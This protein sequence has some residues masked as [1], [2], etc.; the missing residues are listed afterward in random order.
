MDGGLDYCFSEDALDSSRGK[1]PQRLTLRPNPSKQYKLAFADS[2]NVV[3][4][5]TKDS[6]TDGF[7][8]QGTVLNLNY[9]G[10]VR[11]THCGRT[12]SARSPE[13]VDDVRDSVG[14]S[15]KKSL[16][17]RSQE[18]GIPRESMRRILVKDLQLHPYLIQIKH[19]LTQADMDKRVV[20]CQ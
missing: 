7:R 17:R 6:F 8:E 1:N 9:N 20:M 10:I 11:D 5:R 16:R 19:K 14:R 15:P 2:F 3:I 18:L 13:N 4:I 12:V